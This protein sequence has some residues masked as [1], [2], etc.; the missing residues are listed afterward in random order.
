MPTY[1]YRCEKCEQTFERV[2]TMSE[3]GTS[4]PKCPQCGS[5]RIA[6]VP[7]PFIAK[8]TKKS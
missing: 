4:K 1:V 2:E 8:T 5:K 3:H 6:P 7:T